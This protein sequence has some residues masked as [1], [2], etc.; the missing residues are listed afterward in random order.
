MLL[1]L[2]CLLAS[3]FLPSHLSFNNMYLA[4]FVGILFT[5]HLPLRTAHSSLDHAASAPYSQTGWHCTGG[6]ENT[7]DLSGPEWSG[8]GEGEDRVSK[9]ESE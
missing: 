9:S 1:C 7:G 2:V 6:Q 4:D 8:R 5:F 3:F